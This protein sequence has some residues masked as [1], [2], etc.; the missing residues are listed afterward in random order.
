[1]DFP[2]KIQPYTTGPNMSSYVGPLLLAPPSSY[3]IKTKKEELEQ[4]GKDLF[5]QT[6]KAKEL[7][8]VE[9]AAAYLGLP[10]MMNIEEV[11]MHAQED[12]AIMFQGNLEAICFCFPSRWIPRHRLGQ[13]LAQIHT[14]VADGEALVKASPLIA[15]K[16]SDA[17]N[18]SFKRY[19]WT[20]TGSGEL[21]QHPQKETMEPQSLNE[22]YFRLETQI[23]SPLGFPG[24]SV[25]LVNIEVVP[26]MDIWSNPSKKEFITNGINTMSNAI[27]D[28]KNLHGIKSIIN[29]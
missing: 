13:S 14:P 11:A 2:F 19:V 3:Y 17:R 4:F 8:L 21:S 26:L 5:G 29:R 15:Q 9:K 22:L 6:P 28:Y 16:I 18:G 27:L 7:Q 24:A 1:M 23:T 20:I 25:F 12:I 10:Q